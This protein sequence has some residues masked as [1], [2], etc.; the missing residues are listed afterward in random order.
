LGAISCWRSASIAPLRFNRPD[1]GE[2]AG[3]RAYFSE[4]FPRGDEHALRLCEYWR[5]SLLKDEH[6]GS[7]VVIAHGEAHAHWK[8]VDPGQRLFVNLESMWNDFETSVDRFMEMLDREPERKRATL[9]WWSTRQCSVG[10]V[11]YPPLSIV[12]SI[13]ASASATATRVDLGPS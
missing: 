11:T 7:G 3:W 10:L 12:S 6:A 1:L 4:H 2:R 8:L 5:I 13:T 9:E